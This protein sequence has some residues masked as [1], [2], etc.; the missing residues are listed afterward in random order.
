MKKPR[1]LI[2]FVIIILIVI[3]LSAG[4]A[5]LLTRHSDTPVAQT[6]KKTSTV[7]KELPAE[8]T[9][10]DAE[11]LAYN[12]DVAGGTQALDEAIKNTDNSQDQYIYY[13]RKATLLL[14]NHDLN[15]ALTAAVQAYN[16]QKTSNS[17]ALVGQIARSKGDAQQATDYY[18]KAIAAIDPTDPFSKEDKAYYQ[19]V[20]SDIAKGKMSE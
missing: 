12:G 20:V 17:A 5:I 4:A 15:G 1:R 8:K 14:N 19:M 2:I 6:N 9:A 3:G 16:L 11:K 10:D 13:S 7:P 18:N